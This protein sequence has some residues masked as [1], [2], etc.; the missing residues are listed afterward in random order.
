[1][2]VT[3]TRLP[4][5]KKLKAATPVL[6]M[7][8]YQPY[9][10]YTP[11][12]SSGYQKYQAYKPYGHPDHPFKPKQFDEIEQAMSL[13]ELLHKN[14]LALPAFSFVKSAQ[15]RVIVEIDPH[16]VK[17]L[18]DVVAVKNLEYS[19]DDNELPISCQFCGHDYEAS[20]ARKGLCP[21][22]YSVT[23]EECGESYDSKRN[24]RCPHC[25]LLPSF[26]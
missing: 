1:M 2:L 4:A 17:A 10:K 13:R 15:D 18:L 19:F 24:S 16:D 7:Q 14:R 6:P 25:K 20:E 5:A 26:S 9:Q 22:C 11:Y 23:C 12:G 3:I 8:R 21:Q